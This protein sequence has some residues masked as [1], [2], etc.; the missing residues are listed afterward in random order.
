MGMARQRRPREEL[1]HPLLEGAHPPHAAQELPERKCRRRVPRIRCA[2][3]HPR[4]SFRFAGIPRGAQRGISSST[5]TASSVRSAQE[6]QG[7]LRHVEGEDVRHQLLEIEPARVDPLHRLPEVLVV[8]DH[9][10]DQL[11]LVQVHRRQVQPHRIEEHAGDDDAAAAPRTRDGLSHRDRRAAA[12]NSHVEAVRKG[13]GHSVF[14][15]CRPRIVRDRTAQLPRDRQVEVQ[16][17]GH[18]DLGGAG[19]TRR[20]GGQDADR[21]RPENEHPVAR[22]HARLPEDPV[23]S[24]GKRLG[25]HPHLQRSR[26]VQ[27]VRDRRLGDPVFGEGPGPRPDARHALVETDV[28]PPHPAQPARLA[29]HEGHHRDPVAGA[30]LRDRTAALCHRTGKLVPQDD[31]WLPEGVLPPKGVQ[32]GPAHTRIGVPDQDVVRAER[33]RGDLPDLDRARVHQHGSLHRNLHGQRSNRTVGSTTRDGADVA[34]RGA[35]IGSRGRTS[36]ACRIL[37]PWS[38]PVCPHSPPDQTAP[39]H[40][41]LHLA[42]QLDTAR[43]QGRA[44]GDGDV[45]AAEQQATRSDV[46]DHKARRLAEK[47][48]ECLA[49][50]RSQGSLPSRRRGR[51]LRQGHD[52]IAAGEEFGPSPLHHPVQLAPVPIAV[53]DHLAK[54]GRHDGRSAVRLDPGHLLDTGGV[55]RTDDQQGRPL[56]VWLAAPRPS[57]PRQHAAERRREPGRPRRHPEELLPCDQPGDAVE[58]LGRHGIRQDD[59]RRCRS[60]L[61]DGPSEARPSRRGAMRDRAGTPAVSTADRGRS[62]S[63]IL[64]EASRDLA[65][66]PS[67]APV[68]HAPGARRRARPGLPAETP[69]SG[70]SVVRETRP[71]SRPAPDRRCPGTSNR[72]SC[73]PPRRPRAGEP[74]PPRGPAAPPRGP[75]R[76]GCWY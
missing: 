70:L 31:G 32:I 9:R 67:G 7:V 49:G 53:G 71:G 63:V 40:P 55:G 20:H 34:A 12:Q 48:A 47:F 62:A 6:R 61:P 1:A 58:I 50:R 10:T 30:A 36:P 46:P 23:N 60:P 27:S 69:A 29:R 43:A 74:P 44:C 38:R 75:A 42:L 19:G 8:V 45:P 33:R 65:R 51:P 66:S 57:R 22:S 11:Q 39:G 59:P 24:D 16:N 4:I 17:I 76:P 52:G 13:D 28:L 15:G 35:G 21:T 73:T 18:R 68:P 5:F 14:P 64:G 56:P 54:G 72:S 37:R 25:Q 3:G 41:G 26:G 2:L